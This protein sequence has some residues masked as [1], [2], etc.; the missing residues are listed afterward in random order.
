M[1][2]FRAYRTAPDY[3]RDML[4]Y[5][6]E[7]WVDQY[8]A[9]DNNLVM[10]MEAFSLG[11]NDSAYETLGLMERNVVYARE[12]MEAHELPTEEAKVRVSELWQMLQYHSPQSS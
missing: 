1:D 9:L 10:L 3:V 8:E 2:N 6:H 11:K 12:W 4:D 5:P 7:T